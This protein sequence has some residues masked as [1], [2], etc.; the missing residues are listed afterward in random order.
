MAAFVE[1]GTT[2]RPEDLDVGLVSAPHKRPVAAPPAGPTLN[3]SI[4]RPLD[5]IIREV[6]SA[7]LARAL[8]A[9]NGNVEN[10]A[11]RLG[12]SRK[13]LYLKRRRLGFVHEDE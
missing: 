9:E 13:G 5:A 10:A 3:V 8:E 7:V 6:E 12:I 11:K 4:E 1:S 2:I